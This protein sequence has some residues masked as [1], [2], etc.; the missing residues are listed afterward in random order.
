[1]PETGFVQEPST[2][3]C[4]FELSHPWG[5][6]TPVQPG[7]PDTIIFRSVTIATHGVMS[8][9]VKLTMHNTTHVNAPLHL[10]AG[11][12]GIGQVP[13]DRFFGPGLTIGVKKQRWE[14][15]TAADL[16]A[17]NADIREG[18]IVLLNLGWHPLYSDSQEYF[19]EA[20]GL[21][22]DAAEWLV[23][24]KVKMVG[25]D[26]PN[27]DHP[28]ATLLG[29]HRKGPLM[30]RLPKHYQD[31]TGKDPSKA[32]PKFAPAHKA[33]LAAGIP[34]IENVGG[35]LDAITGQRATF[36]A[37]PWKWAEGDACVVRLVAI[38]DPN[39]SYEF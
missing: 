26:T 20:P 14:L 8:H 18:D 31:T 29:N 25:I 28:L 19:G 11:A 32:F 33:L 35:A 10:I 30:R 37:M 34:T 16:E 5:H 3:L 9:R 24:K 38:Q 7:F 4:Y 12:A 39:Q 22:E 21:S 2:G 17:T 15:V 36:H 6:G 23:E 27:I 1:M 13:V